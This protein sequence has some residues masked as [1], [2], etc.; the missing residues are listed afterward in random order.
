MRTIIE[1]AS[2]MLWTV[3]LPV[4]FW[5]AAVKTSVFLINRSPASALTGDI[6]AFKAYFVSKPNL[7]FLKVWGYRAATQVPD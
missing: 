3:G 4:G 6:T 1:H 2:A 7:G 5:A